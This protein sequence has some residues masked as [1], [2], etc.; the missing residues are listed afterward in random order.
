MSLK[1]DY[2]AWTREVQMLN[3]ELISGIRIGLWKHLA[4]S[5]FK[6]LTMKKLLAFVFLLVLKNVI[7]EQK[8]PADR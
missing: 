4:Q 5:I 3:K 7:A 2:K 1:A 6:P 8:C